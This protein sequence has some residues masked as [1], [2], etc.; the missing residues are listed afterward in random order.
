MTDYLL[1]ADISQ[2]GPM[3]GVLLAIAVVAGLVYLVRGRRRTNRDRASDRRP[4][5]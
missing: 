3:I 2:G 1:A 4:E 5:E